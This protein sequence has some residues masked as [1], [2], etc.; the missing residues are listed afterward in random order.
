[1]DTEL[2]T[3]WQRERQRREA[4]WDLERIWPGNEDAKPFLSVLAEIDRQDLEQPLGDAYEMTIDELRDAVPETKFEGSDGYPFMIVLDHH[5][6]QPW[7]SRFEAAS[8]LSTR[9]QEGAYASDWRRFLRC[10]VNEM[11]HLAAHRDISH[12]TKAP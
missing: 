12:L 3:L 8:M 6:P 4:L 2:K 1:M 5:I 11:Q 10:W 7:R 9:L